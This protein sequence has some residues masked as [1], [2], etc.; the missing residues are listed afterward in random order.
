V[1]KQESKTPSQNVQARRTKHVRWAYIDTTFAQL[2]KV[3]TPHRIL[4]NEQINYKKSPQQIQLCTYSDV[5]N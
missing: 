2:T 5:R 4:K 3:R 1:D